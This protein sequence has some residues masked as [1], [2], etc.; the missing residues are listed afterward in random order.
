[1]SIPAELEAELALRREICRVGHSLFS[2]GYVHAT[3]GN[4]SARLSDGFLITPSDACLG[5]LE[6]EEIA[7]V[8]ADGIQLTGARA[9]KA[10]TFIAP[11]TH[12]TPPPPASSTPTPHRSSNSRSVA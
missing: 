7:K 3:A 12:P 6:P 11:S 9:S 2:R 4:I 8:G 10:L 1:M 5:F